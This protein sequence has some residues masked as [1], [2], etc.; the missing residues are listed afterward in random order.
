MQSAIKNT[1]D[2]VSENNKSLVLG[3][4]C[5]LITLVILFAGLWP[6][7]FA[8]VNKV[9][10]IQ[11]GNGIRFY[12]QGAVFSQ[13]PLVIHKTASRNSSVTIELLVRPHKETVNRVRTILT[14]FD[15]N[16]P[17]PF[18]VGQWKKELIIRVPAVKASDRTRYREISVDNAFIKETTHLIAVTSSKERTDVYINGKLSGRF[19]RY[20]LIPQ[21]R[22]L[23]GRILLGNSPDGNNPW[24]GTIIGLAI[25]N[26][27]LDGQDARDHYSSW[28]H[29][30]QQLFLANKKPIALYLFNEHVGKQ[31]ADHSGHRNDLVMPASF[32]PLRKTF[33]EMPGKDQWFRRSNLTDIAINLFGFVPFGFFLSAWL[34][35]V[36]NLTASRVLSISIFS[37]FCL[38]LAI[39][40]TQVYIPTRDSSLMDV[41]SNVLGASIG[42]FLLK[43]TL[44][45]FHKL[46]S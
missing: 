5:L 20:S 6:F 40:L 43:Y 10:W 34:L 23:S 38:S 33:L 27:A 35:Q 29:P 16:Q 19:P 7:D 44:P 18:M 14:L 17:E 9:E 22:G 26:D 41:I 45:I 32:H 15:G 11:N 3:I 46:K 42:V 25:Y 39:E 12:G 31:I 21:D 13:E 36:K 4:I 30:G 1:P 24:N 28:Q 8:P 37:G 2:P